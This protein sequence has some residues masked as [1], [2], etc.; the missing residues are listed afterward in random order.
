MTS[1]HSQI[2]NKTFWVKVSWIKDVTGWGKEE[3]RQAR[4]SNMI[5]WKH[6]PE[7]GFL[8]DLNSIHPIFHNKKTAL[9]EQKP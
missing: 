6:T 1:G 5:T 8:Y 4:E 3:L 9:Q 2:K 7:D